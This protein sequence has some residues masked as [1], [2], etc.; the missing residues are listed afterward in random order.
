MDIIQ[1]TRKAVKELNA[2][3]F[4]APITHVY[5]PL[6]YAREAHECYLKRYGMNPR[7][8]LLLG[9]N[10]GPWGMAQN[11][12]PFGDIVMVRE[13]LDICA[14]VD[15]PNVEHPKRLITGF[16]SKRREG[17]GKRLWG[18]AQDRFGSADNFFK[19]FMV[20]N[21]CPLVFFDESGRNLTPDK[22]TAG[23]REPLLKT[24]D[25]LLRLIV[26]Y[27]QPKHVIGVGVF[28]QKSAQRAL[29][30]CDVNIGRILHPSPAS[31]AANRGWVEAA[32]KDFKESGIEI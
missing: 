8:I 7:E 23:D 25:Q 10:P 27:Y 29:E 18:W 14:P 26:D 32:E 19:R 3:E 24:C 28:A 11:G 21:F 20:V 16:D 5:N 17:S 2:L 22:I 9:M 12:V 31:P 13:W 1:I 15:K 4:S 6:D 30:E